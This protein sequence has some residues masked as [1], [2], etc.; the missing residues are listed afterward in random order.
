MR[1]SYK[2]IEDRREKILN[3]LNKAGSLTIE[4]LSQKL[5]VSEMTVRRDCNNLAQMGRIT[6]KRGVVSF[7]SPESASH[8]DSRERIK[9]SLGQAAAKLVQDHEGNIIFI[10]SS[11]TAIY[12][13]E[14]LLKKNVS[15]I[16]NNGNATKYLTNHDMAKLILTG[17]N[18]NQ[19]NVM[20][21]DIA[22]HSFLSMRSD[23]SIIGCA[24]ISVDQGLS[25]PGIEEAS[26][27]RNIIRNSRRLIV[28]ADYSKFGSFSNFT[29]G[30][31]SDIDVLI[32]DTFV[33]GK[34]LD[35]F[36][37]QGVKVIQVTQ[38]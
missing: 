22:N 34:T 32:T 7:V 13:V 15:I 9:K 12:A 38:I 10:N 21:G 6:Q 1:N 11:S 26:I 29:I 37:K 17:G 31:V 33:S 27:N 23:W 36:R 25:T 24:G 3:A 19:N 30:K 5:G 16:T 20:S 8:S 4:N 14:P 28:V 35:A 18:V 2:N